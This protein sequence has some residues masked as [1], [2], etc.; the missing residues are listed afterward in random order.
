LYQK[1]LVLC[2]RTTDYRYILP[3]QSVVGKYK[4]ANGDRA[5]PVND[6]FRYS[7]STA[8]DG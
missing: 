1:Y 2:F 7:L 6:R 8:Q 3:G 5:G 4:P